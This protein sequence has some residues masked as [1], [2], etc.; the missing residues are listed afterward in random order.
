MTAE[1]GYHHKKS[2]NA[3]NFMMTSQY[4]VQIYTCYKTTVAYKESEVL[5]ISFYEFFLFSSS[6]FL[7]L[8]QLR[9]SY[10]CFFF[11][12]FLFFLFFFSAAE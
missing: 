8:L 4:R 9:N 12:C 7:L 11:F 1:D 2:Q 10:Q 5:S 3:H 6:S